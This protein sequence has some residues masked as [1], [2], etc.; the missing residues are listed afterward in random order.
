MGYCWNP[1]TGSVETDIYESGGEG[2]GEHRQSR[3]VFDDADW[4]GSKDSDE[5][6]VP[7]GSEEAETLF[8]V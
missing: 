5:I 8:Q 2:M 4:G 7:A 6:D 3:R 1:V